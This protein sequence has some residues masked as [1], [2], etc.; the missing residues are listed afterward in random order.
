M[1]D[2]LERQ[3]LFEREELRDPKIGRQRRR[4][5]RRSYSFRD[6]VILRA[7]NQLL[8]QGVSVE[9]IKRAVLAFARDESFRCEREVLT[10][11]QEAVQY[12]VTDGKQIYFKKNG[13]SVV[14]ILE[15]GQG[16]FFFVLDVA[17][18]HATVAQRVTPVRAVKKR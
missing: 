1:L 2:Y 6:V 9:R 3:G 15:G 17:S 4:G 18:A 11:G 12:L 8:E 14:S 7:I 13:S 16:A 10:Y 5:R